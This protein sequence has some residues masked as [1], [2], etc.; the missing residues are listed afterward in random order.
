MSLQT[1]GERVDLEREKRFL[2]AHAAAHDRIYRYFRRRTA[3]LEWANRPLT[4]TD[5]VWYAFTDLPSGEL[6][7]GQT[8]SLALNKP[9]NK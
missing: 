6:A 3:G 8:I 1:M 2:A 4:G 9:I 5:R 7:P